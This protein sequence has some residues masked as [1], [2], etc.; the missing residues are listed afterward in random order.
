MAKLLQHWHEIVAIEKVARAFSSTSS[1]GKAFEKWRGK[2]DPDKE[3]RARRMQRMMRMW[4]AGTLSVMFHAWAE[5]L[6]SAKRDR[7]LAAEAALRDAEEARQR[8]P[9][10]LAAGWFMGLA[11]TLGI[12]IW[13]S[14][15]LGPCLALDL[16]PA[17]A[18]EEEPLHEHVH[19]SAA[20]EDV[21]G[22][23]LMPS[24]AARSDGGQPQGGQPQRMWRASAATVMMVQQHSHG[25]LTVSDLPVDSAGG[26]LYAF[27][28]CAPSVHG[29][30]GSLA[31][32]LGSAAFSHVATSLV[33][34]NLVLMCMPYHGMSES[35]AARIEDATSWITWCF[36]IEMGAKVVALG[37]AHYWSD[38]WNVLDG[39]IVLLSVLEIV[40]TALASGTGVKL[41]FLRMLRML[42]VLRMLRLMRSWR[43]LYKVMQT[44]VEALP[45][46]SNVFVLLFL[47]TMIFALLG[48]ELFGGEFHEAGA[49]AMYMGRAGQTA[50]TRYNFD[51]FVPAMLTCFVITTGGWYTPMLD[52]VYAQGPIA[53]LYYTVVVLVGTYIL[54]NLLVAV[55]LYLFARSDPHE[56]RDETTEEK[57]GTGRQEGDEREWTD[58]G[59]QWR[60]QGATRADADH[61][62]GCG[63]GTG[64]PPE[65]PLR[66]YCR[67]LVELP[68]VEAFVMASAVV[69][70]LMLVWD[71]PRLSP[72]DGLA[73]ALRLA[74]YLFTLIFTAEA[75]CK[76][77]SLGFA[78]TPRAYLKDAWNVLDFALV[79]VSVGVVISETF[80]GLAILRPLRG[81][82]ALRPLRLISRNEG[83]KLVMNSLFEAL[84][85]VANVL[86]VLLFLQLIFAIVGMQMFSG[87]FGI[88]SDTAIN[89]PMLCV[90]DPMPLPPS[91]PPPLPPSSPPA[92]PRAPMPPPPMA[93]VPPTP[94]WSQ[95]P[96]VESEG[97][98]EEHFVT[99]ARRLEGTPSLMPGERVW[100]N[101]L[102]G[103]FDDFGQAMLLLL[104]CA[105]GDDWDLVMY[106]GMDGPSEPGG[107]RVRNDASSTSLFFIIWIFVGSFF[108]MQLFV[109]VVVDEFNQ[110]RAN[111]DGSATMT[112]AQKQWVDTMKSLLHLKG[113]ILKPVPRSNALDRLLFGVASSKA[114][115]NFIIAAVAGNMLVLMSDRWGLREASLEGEGGAPAP[116]FGPFGPFTFGMYQALLLG[117][118]YIFYAEALLKLRSFGLTFYLRDPWCSFEGVLVLV[119]CVSQSGFLESLFSLPP[120][121][122]RSLE[123]ARALRAIRLVQHAKGLRT[124]IA[125]ILWSLPSFLNVT[126]ILLL[127]VFVFSVLGLQLFTFV[128]RGVYFTDYRSKL[129]PRPFICRLFDV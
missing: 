9:A 28:N 104:A 46:M 116:S 59:V 96:V 107:V 87:T 35:Y 82:R 23:P 129:A 56:A 108:A 79:I 66:G 38:G 120:F 69:S 99:R 14:S 101:P 57:G 80:P 111:K 113:A 97:G 112:A 114:F 7:A 37:C 27:C 50:I 86:G 20:E 19:E 109:G 88:C 11:R 12:S 77:V 103:S 15:W 119:S 102:F 63:G 51:Y 89:D 55:L 100:A 125:S 17:A 48:M 84:P 93:P 18:A 127:V 92:A 34:V 1:V 39:T 60:P 54:M 53:C 2:R 25:P 13:L 24:G 3:E 121:A 126:A 5:A 106:H 26:I 91:S 128:E 124:Y 10:A 36:I 70:S 8:S 110:I 52:G 71:T 43:G 49:E 78:F 115:R 62:L 75:L 122:S 29:W 47:I 68:A 118:N 58:G 64:L 72:D 33:V 90:P 22:Q 73:T 65:H 30:R 67:R 16:T 61:A 94:P 98:V 81:L 45:Q 117:F 76:S 41:S 105:T 31:S 42:R 40:L 74:N 44:V 83:M 123:A 95:R 4:K 21:E 6:R 85:A 32:A